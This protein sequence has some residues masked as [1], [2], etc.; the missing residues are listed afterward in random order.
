MK[1]NERNR[2]CVCGSKLKYKNCCGKKIQQSIPQMSQIKF[3]DLNRHA[4]EHFEKKKIEEIIR[5]QQQ[6]LGKPIIS[7]D[8]NGYK[9]IAVG[10]RLHYSP[11]WKTFP[12]FL[13]DFILGKL[14]RDWFNV[15]IAKPLESRHPIMQ[16]HNRVCH[17]QQLLI[18]QPGQVTS[19]SMNGATYCYFG[20]SYSL[21]LLNHNVELQEIYINRLKD[22]NNFQGTYYE[23]MV[24][25][26]LIRA[27]FTLALE[28]ETDESSKHCEFSA[29]SMTTRKKYWVEAKARSVVGVLGKHSK[30][31]TTSTDPTSQ[32]TEHLRKAFQKPANDER[33]IFVDLN[34]SPERSARPTWIDRAGKKLDQKERDLKDG[35]SAYVFV[36]NMCFHW[37]LDSESHSPMFMVHGLGIYDFAKVGHYRLS[38]IYRQKKKHS[39]AHSVAE[40]FISYGKLPITLDGKM[41]SEAYSEVSREIKIG[42]TY[43]FNE[44]GDKGLLAKVSSASVNEVE[45]KMYIGTDGGHILTMPMTDDQLTDYRRH[46]EVYFGKKQHVGKRTEDPYEF[47]EEMVKIYMEHPIDSIREKLKG[48]RDSARLMELGHEDLVLE[49]CEGLCAT[50][51]VHTNPKK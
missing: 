24:A 41:P 33:F 46:K 19:M 27:G 20:L 51:S 23:L 29:T 50:L 13:F 3:K 42:E 14:G 36:T 7:G 5:K 15:E 32:L 11:S 39:D 4:K 8:F 12:D 47:F 35:Q 45:K 22:I 21:Y 26:C 31:G 34:C 9:F 1:G 28:D 17:H 38:E 6:G 43:F 16:W 49:Y 40:A 30:N 18:K 2:P 25:N 10:N 37:D 48:H 44:V